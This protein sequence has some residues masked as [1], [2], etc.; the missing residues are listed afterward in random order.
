MSGSGFD[1]YSVVTH[2]AGLR[3][4]LKG[5]DQGFDLRFL[6]KKYNHVTTLLFPVPKWDDQHAFVV[7]LAVCYGR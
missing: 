7:V 1:R 2:G 5:Q 3:L 6:S 4:T